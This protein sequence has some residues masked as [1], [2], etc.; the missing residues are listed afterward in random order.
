MLVGELGE[1]GAALGHQRLVGGDD[2]D[3]ASQGGLDVGARRLDAA[4]EL[5]QDVEVVAADE[6]GDVGR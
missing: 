1:F 3:A 5:D 6:P 2:R 4:G